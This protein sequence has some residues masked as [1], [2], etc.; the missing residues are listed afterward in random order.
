MEYPELQA[1]YPNIC[2]KL[3]KYHFQ[4]VFPYY[5]C[6]HSAGWLESFCRKGKRQIKSKQHT[7]EQFNK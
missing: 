2:Y 1:R 5:C 4:V 3:F 6:L 7:R